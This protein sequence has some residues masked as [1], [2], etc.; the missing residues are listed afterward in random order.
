M[1]KNIEKNKLLEFFKIFNA[2]IKENIIK[3]ILSCA[4]ILFLISQQNV[5]HFRCSW[6]HLIEQKSSF[7]KSLE[8]KFL[9]IYTKSYGQKTAQKF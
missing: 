4:V 8:S 3:I 7:K 1:S 5:N 9:K 2:K 6:Y